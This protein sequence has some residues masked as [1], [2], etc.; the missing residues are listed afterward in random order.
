M[1]CGRAMVGDLTNM[2]F[3]I[4]TD[5]AHKL[6]MEI[7]NWPL[8]NI[9]ITPLAVS[10]HFCSLALGWIFKTRTPCPEHLTLS[11]AYLKGG[12]TI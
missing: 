11:A 5:F 10:E 4:E 3:G 6:P 2:C 12:I 1:V 7:K 9:F 8:G